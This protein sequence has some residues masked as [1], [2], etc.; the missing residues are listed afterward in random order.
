M[1]LKNCRAIWINLI[2]ILNSV[3]ILKGMNIVK[4]ENG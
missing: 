4:M 1:I 3:K 2:S